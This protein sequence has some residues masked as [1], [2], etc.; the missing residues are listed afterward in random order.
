MQKGKRWTPLN[1]SCDWLNALMTLLARC[2]LPAAPRHGGKGDV[3][4]SWHRWFPGSSAGLVLADLRKT[5]K[6]T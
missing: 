2:P 3:G 1:C 6:E 5:G 4:P